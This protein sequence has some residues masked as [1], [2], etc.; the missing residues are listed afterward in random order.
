MN[1]SSLNEILKGTLLNKPSVSRA[2]SFTDKLHR[3]SFGDCFFCNNTKD[4]NQAIKQGA[5]VIV[6]SK[7]IKTLNEDTAYIRVDTL[8]KAKI[9]L[10]RY[11]LNKHNVNFKIVSKE[12]AKLHKC[13]KRYQNSFLLSN[14]ISKDFSII[15]KALSGEGEFRIISDDEKYSKLLYPLAQKLSVA[16]YIEQADIK[17]CF[18]SSFVY[19][20][21]IYKQINL[22]SMYVNMLVDIS[23]YFK[24]TKQNKSDIDDSGALFKEMKKEYVVKKEI[25]NLEN[26][27]QLKPIYF[28]YGLLPSKQITNR[29][30]I[31]SNIKST[32]DDEVLFLKSK[33]SSYRL[34]VMDYKHIQE[35]G[36]IISGIKDKLSS[37]NAILYIKN[38]SYKKILNITNN[39]SAQIEHSKANSLF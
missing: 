4:I 16:K 35:S 12:Y 30:I 28:D 27:S 8:K 36:D 2:D 24:P 11:L 23:L 7:D 1:I 18:Y 15:L 32:Y 17:G 6:T 21:I 34:W 29:F 3:V 39:Q 20:N 25:P 13:F 31:A 33:F 9:R 14:K 10:I 26:F 5:Y 22:P 19:Q 38:I 37:A